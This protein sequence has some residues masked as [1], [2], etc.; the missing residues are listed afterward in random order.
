M[1]AMKKFAVADAAE[2]G[3][4]GVGILPLP[5]LALFAAHSA[6]IFVFIIFPQSKQITKFLNDLF[7]LQ[8]ASLQLLVSTELL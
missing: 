3:C 8:N 7:H 6:A 5:T 4:A 1:I 2:G